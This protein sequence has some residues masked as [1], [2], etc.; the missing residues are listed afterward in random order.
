MAAEQYSHGSATIIWDHCSTLL[1]SGGGTERK[2]G[3]G[4]GGGGGSGP[5][6]SQ[7]V[8]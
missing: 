7:E 4:G 3:G 1:P 6:P 8:G 5:S 2:G